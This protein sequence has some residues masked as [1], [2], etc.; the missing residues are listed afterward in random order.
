MGRVMDVG[1]V[2]LS[3]HRCWDD[4]AYAEANG[5][6]TA[7][8]VDSPLIAGDPFVAMALTAQRTSRLRIGPMLAIPSNRSAA[9]CV[10]A[11]A[12]VNRIAPGRTFLGIGTGFTA[13]GF[14][15]QGA[16]RR[17]ACRVRA[18][19]SQPPRRA[20]DPL[21]RRNREP[22]ESDSPTGLATT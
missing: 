7:G 11:V 1:I 4:A 6:A 10:T 17:P 3:H 16:T 12:S 8:F 18:G 2:L 14:R 13:R 9:A 5:F 19:L 15:T 20:R 21:P 22:R